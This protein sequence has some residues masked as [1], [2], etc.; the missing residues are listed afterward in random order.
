MTRRSLPWTFWPS[1]WQPAFVQ[2]AIRI[3]RTLRSKLG[4][5]C[6]RSRR[7][8]IFFHAE[9]YCTKWSYQ[10]G[11]PATSPSKLFTIS[12]DGQQF[13]KRPS[14]RLLEEKSACATWQTHPFL[15]STLYWRRSKSQYICSFPRQVHVY[16]AST[17][18]SSNLI[19]PRIV[20]AKDVMHGKWELLKL[21][22][23]NLN[24]KSWEKCVIE[25]DSVNFAFLQPYHQLE[26]P[27]FNL[28]IRYKRSLN[29]KSSCPY[30]SRY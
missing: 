2:S 16:V 17:E 9:H 30:P 28:I 5:Y 13:A 15:E 4:S 20:M 10:N 3:L 21:K 6:C 26:R 1:S 18:E 27:P 23:M 8:V 25:F 12:C 11:Q 7:P 24:L 19:F 29:T 22:P 14:R